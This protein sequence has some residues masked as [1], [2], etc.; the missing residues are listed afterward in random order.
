MT[1]HLTITKGY[2]DKIDYVKVPGFW[3]SIMNVHQLQHAF[4]SVSDEIVSMDWMDRD[5]RDFPSELN[6]NIDSSLLFPPEKI[7]DGNASAIAVVNYVIQTLQGV[8]TSLI[9]VDGNGNGILSRLIQ[10]TFKMEIAN[11]WKLRGD[12]GRQNS[13]GNDN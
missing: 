12:C 10:M 3:S 9:F 11:Q 1:G 2:F 8:A 5:L 13:N 4:A 7:P 6:Q